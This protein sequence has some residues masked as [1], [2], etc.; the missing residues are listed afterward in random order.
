MDCAYIGDSI[1]V[2][3][4]QLD[5]NCAVYAR[6]GASSE[7]ITRRYRNVDADDYVVISMGSND[8]NNPRLLENAARLRRT[9]TARKVIWILPYNRVA[10]GVISIVAG[11]FRDSVVDLRPVPSRDA[12][13]PNYRQVNRAIRSKL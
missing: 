4:E 2:G 12:V 10:A 13:H 6:V 1:A 9:I 11:R 8:P 5:T 7:F 3:L